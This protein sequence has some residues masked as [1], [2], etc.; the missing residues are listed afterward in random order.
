M[1]C[2]K[3]KAPMELVRFEPIEVDRCTACK[4][5]FFD[6]TEAEALKKLRGSE[7]I[8]VGDAAVGKAQNE[9]DRIRCPRD[10]VQMIRIVDPKQ[11]HLWLE[12]CPVCSG[13]FF[14]AGELRDWKHETLLD[15]FRGLFAKPRS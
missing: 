15:V 12:T 2:P 4:G 3:C 5:I 1:K 11:P 8:D 13:T 10:T 9:N 7:A 6:A 14:D